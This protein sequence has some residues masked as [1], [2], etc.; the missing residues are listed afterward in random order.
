MRLELVRVADANVIERKGSGIRVDRE[1]GIGDCYPISAASQICGWRGSTHWGRGI[2]G[3]EGDVCAGS[4]GDAAGE[5]ICRR[6]VDV[7]TKS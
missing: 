4:S 2:C 6:L 7:T 3:G 5:L 1:D